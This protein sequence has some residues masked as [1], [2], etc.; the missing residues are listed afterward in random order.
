MRI[1]MCFFY[2]WFHAVACGQ[3]RRLLNSAFGVLAARARRLDVVGVI[4]R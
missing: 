1:T 2:S 4:M 3:V